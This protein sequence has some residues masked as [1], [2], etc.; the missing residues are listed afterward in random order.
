MDFFKKAILN[1]IN[2]SVN[3]IQGPNNDLLMKKDTA[4]NIITK[5]KEVPVFSKL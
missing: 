2:H 3:I 1:G 5:E 4:T